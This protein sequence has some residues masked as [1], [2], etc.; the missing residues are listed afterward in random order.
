MADATIAKLAGLARLKDKPFYVQAGCIEPHRLAGGDQAAD[1][2]FLGPDLQSD[3]SRGVRVPPY[4][5]DTQGTR[6]ELAELQGAV[7]HKNMISNVDYLPTTLELLGLPAPPDV[8]GR[9]LAN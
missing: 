5:R 7:R 8:Q 3:T 2:G 9:S 4:L 6:M 1:I